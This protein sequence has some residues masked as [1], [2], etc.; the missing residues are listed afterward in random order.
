METSMKTHFLVSSLI[1]GFATTAFSAVTIT[2]V[3][4]PGGSSAVGSFT[5]ASCYGQATMLTRSTADNFIESPGY[6]CIESADLGIP[7]DLNG[8]RHVNGIDLA[9]ILGSW[10]P[11]T[12]TNCAA[13]INGDSI[14]NGVDLAIVLSSWG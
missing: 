7:G 5:M 1:A 6:L 13:D 11:C 10:G 2:T 8:D 4:L 9:I 14:I 3:A 12:S